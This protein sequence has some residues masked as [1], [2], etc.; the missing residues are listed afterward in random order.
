MRLGEEIIIAAFRETV[1]NAGMIP[2][3]F[4]FPQFGN[5]M[6]IVIT[7]EIKDNP[8]MFSSNSW[9]QIRRVLLFFT[10]VRGGRCPEG[11]VPSFAGIQPRRAKTERIRRLRAT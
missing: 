1:S 2:R 6:L 11:K 9:N 7:A 5:V 8:K 3:P 4:V 10:A